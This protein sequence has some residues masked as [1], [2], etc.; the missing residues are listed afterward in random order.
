MTI[1]KDSKNN[2]NQSKMN[3][4]NDYVAKYDQIG[5][6]NELPTQL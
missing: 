1:Q 2:H 3:F 4:E 5:L 6:P